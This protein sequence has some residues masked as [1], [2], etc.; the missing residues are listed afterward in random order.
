MIYLIA[1]IILLLTYW[2]TSKF[3]F[4]L[5]E[6]QT[7]EMIFSTIFFIFILDYGRS[8]LF[9]NENDNYLFSLLYLNWYFWTTISTNLLNMD[10]EQNVIYKN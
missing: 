8:L 10:R 5:T 2:I 7:S 1:T 9:N 3:V 6:Q 4:I